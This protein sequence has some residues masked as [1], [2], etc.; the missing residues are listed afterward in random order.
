MTP[1]W[2]S[3]YVSDIAYTLG[4]YRELAP[5]FLNYVCVINGVEG[6]PIGTP[7]RYCE[8][9]C[10]RGYGTTLLAAANPDIE[11][12][13]IDFNPLHINEA[14][15]FANRA[16]ISNIAFIEISFGDAARS[17]DPL[18]AE[19]DIVAL[20]GVFTWVSP[21]VRNDIIEFMRVRLV[22]GGLAYVSYNTLPGWAVLAPVQHILKE[23]AGHAAGDSLARIE[24]GIA[25]LKMLADKSSAYV[26]R[27]PS[28]KARVEAFDNEDQRYLAHEFL[29]D[30]WQPIYI[31][32]ALESLAEAKL[33]YVGSATIGENRLVAMRTEGPDR[34]GP[35]S[36][37]LGASRIARRI[38]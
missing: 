35:V 17:N 34:N 16:G 12:V 29:N 30:N 9:G 5:S 3:G 22:P 4:F 36:A 6:I 7:L 15:A 19:F 23:Y 8:L 18:L 2:M 20:H 38:M 27:N 37:R 33:T 13:G 1:A 21:K 26:A 25:V 32:D 11:F 28:V 24:K 31:T 10:G 14:R